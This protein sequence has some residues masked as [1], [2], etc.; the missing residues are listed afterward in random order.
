M[1]TE[2]QA[3][4]NMYFLST[5]KA[6]YKNLDK[7]IG[8]FIFLF[9]LCCNAATQEQLNAVQE[10]AKAHVMSII[11]VPQNGELIVHPAN[12]DN[13]LNITACPS[14]LL[15]SSSSKASRTRNITVRVECP[16][17][18]WKVYVP[19]RTKLSLPLVTATRSLTKGEIVAKHDLTLTMKELNVYRRQG[20]TLPEQVAG[21]KLKKNIRAGDVLERNDVCVVCRNEKVVIKAVKNQ[22]TITTKGTALTDGSH[23]DQVRVRNDKSKR[24]VEGIVTDIAEITVYF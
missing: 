9:S 15:T 20:F 8:F 16:D 19:V 1:I 11:E 24:I 21:A 18:N 4:S 12:L 22:M 13:R 14:P 23:G 17:D 2:L 6:L 7:S 5:Y 10:A 3:K